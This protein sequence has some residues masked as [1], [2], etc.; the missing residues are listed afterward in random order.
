MSEPLDLHTCEY[1]EKAF[2]VLGKRWTGLLVDLLLQRPARFNELA[3]AVPHLSKRVLGERLAELGESG[4][5]ERHVD[6][7]PP[8]AV[9]YCLTDRGARL[10]PA[11][12]ALKVWAGAPVD[13][14]GKLVPPPPSKPAPPVRKRSA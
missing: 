14:H 3:K 4:L 9:T 2:E 8:V 5:V 12:E 1:A 10:R 6:P 11:I 7:G 13:A